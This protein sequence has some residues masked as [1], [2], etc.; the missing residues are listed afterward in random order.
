[1][2][3]LVS[4]IIPT[5]NCAFAIGE[6]LECLAKQTYENWEAIVIDDGSS[7]N[8]KDTIGHY[9]ARDS[10]FKYIRQE[11]KGVSAARNRGLK[12]SKGEY[13]QFLDADD[14]IS[15]DKIEKQVKMMEED[16]TIDISYTNA[17]YFADTDKSTLYTDFALKNVKWMTEAS[18]SGFP[19]V[20]ALI[21][22]NISPI[23][24]PLFKKDSCFPIYFNEDLTHGEDWLFWFQLAINNKKFYYFDDKN[25]YSLVRVHGGS[26][27]QSELKMHFGVIDVRRRMSME[28][29]GS[30]FLNVY[31]KKELLA[32]NDKFYKQ[33][34]KKIA[35]ENLLS[36]KVLS[37]LRRKCG[38]K[39]MIKILIKALNENRKSWFKR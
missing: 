19:V 15:V 31:E 8:T 2:N 21:D 35:A 32:Y 34:L 10:R 11:N 24:S 36:P 29:S 13:I 20:K 25:S 3:K 23:Q 1:M 5:Y 4:F 16:R 38:S 27:S 12:T 37:N 33:L 14:L 6:T 22:R 7:D 18:G 26:A 28:I 17:F 39:L 30:P 9:I